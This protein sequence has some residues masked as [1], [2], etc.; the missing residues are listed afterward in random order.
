[1]MFADLHHK[2]AIL[3]ILALTYAGIALGHIPGL[4]LNRPGIVL[5]GA[6]GMMIFGGVS[7][8]EVVS[9][10]NWPTIFL[11]FAFFVIS[12]QLRLSGFYH[13]VAGG[14]SARLAHP[15]QFL[16]VLMAA[17]AGLSAF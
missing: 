6:I 10:V 12:A 14:I 4:K 8:A 2:P 9:Y 7:T 5:L 11:L 17:T 16:F 13:L 3:F 1:M 15:A